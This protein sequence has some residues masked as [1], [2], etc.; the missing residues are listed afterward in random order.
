MTSGEDE[1]KAASVENWRRRM[2]KIDPLREPADA[3]RRLFYQSLIGVR[4]MPQ[5]I[6]DAVLEH[7]LRVF[8]AKTAMHSG[9]GQDIR[10]SAL[11]SVRGAS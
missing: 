3:E 9:D 8:N 7:G 2:A 1:W 11:P 5:K 10:H 4:W 6:K